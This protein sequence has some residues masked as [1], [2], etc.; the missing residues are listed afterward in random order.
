MANRTCPACGTPMKRVT[1]PDFTSDRCPHCGGIFLDKDEL[2]VLATGLAGDIEY[3]SL[4]ENLHNDDH[5]VRHCPRCDG[6]AMRKVNLL[7]FSDIVFDACP[8]CESFFLD[9][10]ELAA[11][12]RELQ[13][14]TPTHAAQELREYRDGFLVRVDLVSQVMPARIPGIGANPTP[15]TYLRIE[16]FFPQPLPFD[17]RIDKERW[18]ATL[19][20]HFGLN[21]GHDI[22]IGHERFDR[23]FLVRGEPADAV[24]ESLTPAFLDAM[25]DFAISQPQVY[26][27]EGVLGVTRTEIM[28]H[29][30]PYEIHGLDNAVERSETVLARLV[31][32]ARLLHD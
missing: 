24:R 1:E 22:R 26:T 13:A 29:E 11:M 14:L 17:L 18:Y 16:V 30:G 5:A 32:L 9:R 31:E 12:N 2:N 8:R 20:H 27:R 25:A 19:A 15:A 4:D 3:C 10:G 28:Y 23:H 21:P 6:E 7:A